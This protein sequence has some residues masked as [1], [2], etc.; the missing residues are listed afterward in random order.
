MSHLKL[1]GPRG[2][3]VCVQVVEPVFFHHSSRV[4]ERYVVV[5]HKFCAPLLHSLRNFSMM[6]PFGACEGDWPS[7]GR[8]SD[9]ESGAFT[10]P[11]RRAPR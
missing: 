2:L 3:A 4:V 8:A 10:E 11:L 5:A 9:A 6:V 1:A 7:L